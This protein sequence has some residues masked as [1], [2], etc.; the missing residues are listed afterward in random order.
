[1]P[2]PNKRTYRLDS[3]DMLRGLVIIIMAIDHVRDMVMLAGV[4]DPLAQGDVSV[5]LYLTR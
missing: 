5:G 3:I 2:S 1:M 4:Q